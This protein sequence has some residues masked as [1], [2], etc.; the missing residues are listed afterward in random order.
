MNAL[1]QVKKLVL[2]SA[3]GII[4]ASCSNKDS[5]VPEPTPS[6]ETTKYVLISMSENTLNKPGFATAFDA[7]PSGN[8][9]NNGSNSLQGFGF[10]G[11][12]PYA[13]GF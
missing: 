8:I 10:G 6:T 4:T 5:V 2:F 13:I 7:L 3:I 11:W 1:K 12:R 9:I